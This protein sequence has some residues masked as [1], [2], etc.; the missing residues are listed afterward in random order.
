MS[1]QQPL[2]NDVSLLKAENEELRGIIREIKSKS[3]FKNYM[4]IAEDNLKLAEQLKEVQ[5]RVAFLE[6]MRS[7]K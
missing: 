2:Q 3:R 4:K 6:G 5:T 7:E 1:Y